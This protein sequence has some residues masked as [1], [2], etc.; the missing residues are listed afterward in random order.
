MIKGYG[1]GS[2]PTLVIDVC[3]LSEQMKEEAL[4]IILEEFNITKHSTYSFTKQTCGYWFLRELS[5]PT[6]YQ[7]TQTAVGE[8]EDGEESKIT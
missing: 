3:Y 6:C 7:L 4:K 1:R 5:K 8:M 2:H